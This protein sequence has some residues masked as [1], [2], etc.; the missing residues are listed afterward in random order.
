MKI[1][2]TLF[3]SLIGLVALFSSAQNV[4]SDAIATSGGLNAGTSTSGGNT[5]YGYYAGNS[6]TGWGNT[7]IGQYAGGYST[8]SG[9][10][11]IGSLVG[12]TEGNFNVCIGYNSAPEAGINTSRNV[13]IGTSSGFTETGSDKLVIANN[14]EKQLI[15]GDFAENKLKFNAKVGIGFGFGNYPTSAGGINL[16]NYNLFVKGG[17][18]SEEI[19]VNLQSEWADYVFS[20]DYKLPSIEEV[21]KHIKDK[22]HLPNVPSAEKVKEEGIELGEMAKIQ[23]EKIEE[24]TLYIIALNKKLEAQEKRLKE[25]EDNNK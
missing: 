19:R 9:N 22:G 6:S 15:W 14:E 7:F 4:Q 11:L 12:S 18:L 16:T 2:Q 8:G 20:E 5:F 25:L 23:Q 10:T 13:F 24:L 3:T 21:E 17:I 1:T